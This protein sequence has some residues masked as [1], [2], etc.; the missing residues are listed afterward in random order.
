[1]SQKL[2]DSQLDLNSA[3]SRSKPSKKKTRNVH[4][5]KNHHH[6]TYSHGLQDTK[7]ITKASFVVARSRKNS[8]NQKGNVVT[9]MQR[10]LSDGKSP[11]SASFNRTRK[12]MQGIPRASKSAIRPIHLNEINEATNNFYDK[13]IGA[14]FDKY[15]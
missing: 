9:M 12:S 1:M 11:R 4:I 8:N 7:L 2:K 14:K 5:S 15:K 13:T 10:Q 3:S 6:T